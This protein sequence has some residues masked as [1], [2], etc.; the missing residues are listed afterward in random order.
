MNIFFVK[1]L[2]ALKD[3]SA[4]VEI[5]RMT[6]NFVVPLYKTAS[7]KRSTNVHERTFYSDRVEQKLKWM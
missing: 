7:I 2:L 1:L 6:N 3:I 5:Q 4:S